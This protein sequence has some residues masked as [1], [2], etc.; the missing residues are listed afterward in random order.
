[1]SC[2]VKNVTGREQ[3]NSLLFQFIFCIQWVLVVLGCEDVKL[4]IIIEYGLV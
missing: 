1:M 2:I 4:M 3:L